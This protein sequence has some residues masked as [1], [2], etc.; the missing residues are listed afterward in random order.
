VNGSMK[1]YTGHFLEVLRRTI[2]MFKRANICEKDASINT[3]E[4]E[5]VVTL[6][7]KGQQVFKAKSM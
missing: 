2:G 7:L 1:Y 6:I 4:P 3:Y 5:S